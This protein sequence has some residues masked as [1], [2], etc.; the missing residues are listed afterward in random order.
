MLKVIDR[1]RHQR[2][3]LYYWR[4][5]SLTETI[6]YAISFIIDG[7]RY[8]QKPLFTPSFRLLTNTVIDRNRY[9]CRY[10]SQS[11][12]SQSSFNSTFINPTKEQSKSKW[13]VSKVRWTFPLFPPIKSWKDISPF[14]RNNG[15][16]I[17]EKETREKK[18]LVYLFFRI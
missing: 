14:M 15:L 18:N 12:Y 16:K 4:K 10:F 1:N 13:Y 17:D 7:N 2:H 8:W 3:L 9:R 11:K 6:I 5:P